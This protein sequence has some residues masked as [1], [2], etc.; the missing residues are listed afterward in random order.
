[1]T[2]LLIKMPVN[3]VNGRD[4]GKKK[5]KKAELI[6]TV[7]LRETPFLVLIQLP[8]GGCPPR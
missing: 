5:K 7:L 1:M 4:A 6:Y 2:P 3:I 8:R